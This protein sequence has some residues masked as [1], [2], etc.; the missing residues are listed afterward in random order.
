MNIDPE[1]I[2]TGPCVV[3]YK[4]TELGATQGGVKIAVD[5]DT[6]DIKCDQSYGQPVKRIVTAVK[7]AVTMTLLQIDTNIDLLLDA[8]KITAAVLGSDLLAKGGVLLLT[9][10][11]A[12]AAGS[13]RFPNAV[14]E[15]GSDY[16]LT[17]TGAHTIQ[18]KFTAWP[19]AGGVFL[20]KTSA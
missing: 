4:G 8:G 18:V 14:L 5:M 11:D 1:K 20:E 15:P 2:R 6:V 9:P 3:T 7:L 13:Y 10:V 19:D 16:A 17:E 12:P